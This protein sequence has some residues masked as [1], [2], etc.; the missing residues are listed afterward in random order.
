MAPDIA[1]EIS[2]L[3]GWASQV[4]RASNDLGSARGY[5]TGN[6]ADADFGRIL[7]VITGD[8]A[9]MLPRIHNILQADST[10][11]DHERAALNASADAYKDVDERSRDHF[12]QLAGG[13]ILHTADDGV[14]NGFNDSLFAAAML[15]PPNGGGVVLPEVSFGWLLDQVCDLIVWVGGPDPRE[16]VTRWIVGDIDKAALQASAWQHVADCVDAVDGNLKSGL[17]AITRTWT[18]SASTAAGAQ[19]AKWGTCLTDQSSKMWQLAVH[20]GDAVDQAVKMAQCVVDIIKVVI[21]IV[22][23]ALSN[24]A[25]PFYGQWKLIK[26]VKEAITMVNSARKVIM[27]FWNFLNLVK[28]FIQLCISTFT[29]DALPPAPSTAAVPV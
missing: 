3:R 11:L 6:I 15:T 29:A 8:Y 19:M 20:L 7:E 13:A 28:S 12:T 14:A 5:A 23:A 22:S 1:V 17:T 16:Y 2:D 4:G 9:A 10:G 25:I 26:T 27:V 24:A 18:G 21:S